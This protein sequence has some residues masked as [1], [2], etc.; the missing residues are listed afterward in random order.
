MDVNKPKY[1]INV[2]KVKGKMAE[3]GYNITAFSQAIGVNRNTLTS[4]FENPSTIPYG[5]LSLMASIL[6]DDTS[7]CMSLFLHRTDRR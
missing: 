3:K 5:K 2:P 7:E 1:F 4:Y 6:C